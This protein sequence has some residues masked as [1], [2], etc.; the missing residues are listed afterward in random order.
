MV[1]DTPLQEEITFYNAYIPEK[2][3]L[4]KKEGLSPGV[5]TSE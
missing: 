4:W 2:V 3:K 5:V 1:G